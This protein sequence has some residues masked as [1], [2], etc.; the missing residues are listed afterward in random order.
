MKIKIGWLLVGY[1]SAQGAAFSVEDAGGAGTTRDEGYHGK[2]QSRLAAGA[3]ETVNNS[4]ISLIY[5]FG[6]KETDG[7]TKDA[8]RMGLSYAFAHSENGSWGLKGI[9]PY[10]DYDPGSN[11]QKDQAKGFGDITLKL[12]RSF[13]LTRK[14]RMAAAVQSTLNT[15][16]ADELGKGADTLGVT[17]SS[18]YHINNTWQ[19]QLSLKYDESIHTDPGIEDSSILLITPSI[20]VSLPYHLLCKVSYDGKADFAQDKYVSFAKV[21][22]NYL[23]GKKKNWLVSVGYKASLDEGVDKYA[24]NGGATYHF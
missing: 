11:T 16:Q 2:H 8:L 4:S 22:V 13:I 7:S 1:L 18:T 23:F 15:A 19:G 17:G 20:A 21:G 5:G 14:L 6:E 3:D 9:I 10:G 24:L 12:N